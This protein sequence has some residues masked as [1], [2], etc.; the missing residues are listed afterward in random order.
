MSLRRLPEQPR[1]W[2]DRGQ[3]LRFD[4]EGRSYDGFAGDTLT[5][6]LAAHGVHVLGRSFKY[7]RPRGICSLANHDVNALV[8]N[9]SNTNV[10]ADVLELAAGA[11]YRA[12]NTF[13][14]LARDRARLLDRFGAFLPVGFYYKTFHRPRRWF[15]F[16]E[17]RMRA[18][19]GLGAIRP[20][21]PRRRTPKRYDFCDVLVIGAGPSGLAAATAAADCGAKAV[22][23]DEQRRPGG[24][25]N[26]Q[27]VAGPGSENDA[28]D[29]LRQAASRSNVDI[30]PDTVAAGCYADCFV[31]LVDAKRLTKMR[32]RSIVMATGAFEQPAVFGN[33]DLPGVI[34]ATAAQRLIHLFAVRPFDRCVVLAA[35]SD[36]YRA[37]LDLAGAGVRVAA[38]VDLRPDGETGALADEVSRAKIRTCVSHA[39]YQAI[40]A[41]GLR[42]I[43]AAVVCPLAADGTPEPQQAFDIA[44]DGI[45]MSVGWAPA[46]GPFCQAGG[47][48]QWSDALQQFV[49]RS[50][51]EG[52]FVAGR[53]NGIYALDDRILDGRRA[54]LAAAAFLGLHSAPLPPE[55]ARPAASPNHPYPIVPHP[56]AKSFV[57][58]DEDVQYKDLVH[59][60]QE[61]FDQ[62]ELAKRYSTFGMGPSQGKLA[63]TN[64]MRI[65]AR[66]NG[67]TVA[68]TGV[69][70]SRPFFHPVP[71]AHLAGR[72]FH[73]QRRTPL[74]ER[75][76]QA[77]AVFMPA[78]DWLRP[79]YYAPEG[80]RRAQAIR[81]EALAVR[82]AVGLIDIGTLGKLEIIGPDAAAFLERVYTGKFANLPVGAM[83][84]ALACDESGVIIDD[85]TVARLADD[86]FYVTTTTTASA[87]V[88]REMQRWAII[89]KLNVTIANVTGSF[90]GVNVAGPLSRRIL[91]T[92]T[93]ADC[94]AG[95][96]PYQA[97]RSATV[98]GVTA[99]L[100]RVGFVG[101]LGYEIHVPAY[102]ARRVWDALVDAGRPHG[103]R[104]F[105]VE[106]QRLLR[107]E[108]G[109]VIVSQD[110][111]GLTNPFEAQLAW[112][113]KSDKPFFVGGR[114]LEILKRKPLSR[115]L[116][117]FTLATEDL[118]EREAVQ[119]CHLIIAG[120]HIAGRVT[121]IGCSAVLG[122]TIGLAYVR[123]EMAAVGSPLS[124]RVDDGR[125]VPATV[126]RTPF[127]DPKNE[128]QT[129]AYCC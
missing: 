51:P 18:L 50:A 12:V 29:L 13:G 122:Q 56:H 30:R 98:A 6:A 22:V 46:D 121:S 78:G 10:R 53:L 49:P 9:G 60:V 7:H 35:N 27:C 21:A 52:I 102:G 28:A 84:Y 61:G 77:G 115:K 45:A 14:G 81:A 79:A 8:Q 67:K 96:I 23:V 105:G 126:A 34:L 72:G 112:A 94:S 4:F 107:L 128:R 95:A 33:N 104:P 129:L 114:S 80:E 125:M 75:H 65:I 90:A 89:W 26:Y 87:S 127:Y 97:V 16:F 91:Q 20:D 92:L 82:S 66:A 31:A 11:S 101:E 36:G 43:R 39:V 17:R 119:E 71:L 62:V 2:I 123:P 63:N 69:P 70:R 109:H 64:A 47:R 15:P 1:E 93:D 103:I 68:E 120:G 55:V 116:V 24:S 124:I 42:G 41:A 106:A 54:G 76:V 44:C 83:R 108:K 38:I 32:A 57:D 85:G 110:T 111:D 59:S 99:R 40:P 37:A 117:G 100:M 58:L 5:S 19:A 86:R 3:S 74:H 48:M 88:Y 113:V 73:P 25:L 118:R